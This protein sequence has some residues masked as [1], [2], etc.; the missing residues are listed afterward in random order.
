MQVYVE[1]GKEVY[2]FARAA[3]DQILSL[4]IDEAVKTGR[5]VQTGVQPWAR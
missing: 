3:Q 1:G 2:S 4:A 5:P